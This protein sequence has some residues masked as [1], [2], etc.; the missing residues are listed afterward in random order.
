M[1]SE[2]THQKRHL[3]PSATGIVSRKTKQIVALAC[4]V[5]S[6]PTR[7]RSTIHSVSDISYLWKQGSLTL[8]IEIA[9]TLHRPNI[10]IGGGP[11]D[12]MRVVL[13]IVLGSLSCSTIAAFNSPCRHTNPTRS[14]ISS[15][16]PKSRSSALPSSSSTCLFAEEPLAAEGDWQA[17]L[18]EETTGL[19]YYFNTQTG[20]SLWEPP[21]SS[22]PPIKLPRRKQRLAESLRTDYRL[23]RQAEL[24]GTVIADTEP[25]EAKEEEKAMTID[26]EG[27]DRRTIALPIPTRRY[28]SMLAGYANMKMA[29]ASEF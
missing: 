24:E 14:T 4:Q 16:W 7:G 21:T 8:Y 5:L 11:T 23:A 9:S 15:F 3:Y 29:V 26:F 19:V 1:R 20:Q 2:P 6:T 17:Y 22:F 28:T 10:T 12:K 18:D 13:S 25:E 27:A